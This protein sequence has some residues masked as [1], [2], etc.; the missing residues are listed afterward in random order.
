MLQP[1]VDSYNQFKET[2]GATQT[3]KYSVTKHWASEKNQTHSNQER[4]GIRCRL[5][6]LQLY[7]QLT[8]HE[9]LWL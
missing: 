5:L 8:C 4:G 7:I 9:F 2:A 6:A 1:S 3:S